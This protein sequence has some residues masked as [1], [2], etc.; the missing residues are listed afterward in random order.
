MCH[1]M[2]YQKLPSSST[3][4]VSRHVQACFLHSTNNT[5][6]NTHPNLHGEKCSTSGIRVFMRYGACEFRRWGLLEFQ[7][8]RHRELKS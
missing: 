5:L 4:S 8:L 1:D 3:I 6:R 7:S 2:V